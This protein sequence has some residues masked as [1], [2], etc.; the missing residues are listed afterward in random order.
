MTPHPQAELLRAIADGQQ[1]QEFKSNWIDRT[2]NEALESISD[3]VR[4]VRI[5]PT[6]TIMIGD[7]EVPEPMRVAPL[8]GTQFWL[9]SS[10]SLHPSEDH[11]EWE[12]MELQR[13][14]LK[15]GLLHATEQGARQM[16]AA[17]VKQL[18]WEL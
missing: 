2:P 5:K 17:L 11:F 9:C 3:G 18:G 16:L 15:R 13:E 12:G 10:T 1:M 6:P 7:M 4:E 14:W 8:V